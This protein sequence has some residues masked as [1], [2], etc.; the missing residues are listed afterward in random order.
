MPN[1][2]SATVKPVAAP[3]R[4]RRWLLPLV[5]LASTFVIV[6]IVG[7]LAIKP[8]VR[9]LAIEGA[10]KRG[11]EL[12]IGDLEVSLSRIQ[13]HQVELK[14]ERVRHL[15]LHV[16]RL[17][18]SLDGFEPDAFTATGLSVRLD[19]KSSETAADIADWMKRHPK[20]FRRSIT[21]S[22]I[23]VTFTRDDQSEP[24]FALTGGELRPTKD[25]ARFRASEVKLGGVAVSQMDAGWSVQDDVIEFGLGH[26]Q[27][28][29]AP[30]KVTFTPD[31]A[32]PKARVQLKR[33]PAARLAAPLHLDKLPKGVD[34]SLDAKLT[35]PK[36]PGAG[37]TEGTVKL[38]LHDYSPKLPASV[39]GLAL[40]KD[41]VVTSDV[42]I[43][44]A[45]RNVA[46][47]KLTVTLGPFK[48]KGSGA[49]Q[50]FDDAG[51]LTAKLSGSL[52]CADIA[53]SAA[54]AQ[55][56]GLAGKLLGQLA[57][58]TVK[59]GVGVTVTVTADS[60]NL[61]DAAIGHKLGIGCG[62]KVP[63]LTLGEL[64]DLKSLPDLAKKLPDIP[65]GLPQLPD[66]LKFPTGLPVPN[67]P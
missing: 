53:R 30:L 38:T 47:T 18:F 9:K 8:L 51:T 2:E 42:S 40:G 13:L 20:G 11:I 33:T 65:G 1:A 34:V 7:L 50:R 25:G 3:K 26:L 61:S 23:D 5:L 37:P 45:L 48:L 16:E 54:N 28:S 31:P 10:A 24:W 27:P 64:P 62:L 67:A 59:G 36:A 29:R 6:T 63:G 15:S 60:R 32:A 43:D 14:L 21:G 46:M 39:P 4:K 41:T 22:K 35:L 44:A 57:T 19:G 49:V 55:F 66:G 17:G 52:A 56:P 58:N 12:S